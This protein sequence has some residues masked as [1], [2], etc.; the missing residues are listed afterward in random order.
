MKKK[1]ILKKFIYELTNTK[2]L[3]LYIFK[4]KLYL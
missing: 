3:K 4:K 2:I 1:N